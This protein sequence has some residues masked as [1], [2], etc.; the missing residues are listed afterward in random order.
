MF[1]VYI[2]DRITKQRSILETVLTEKQAIKI[3]ESWAWFYTDEDNKTY[4]LE[5]EENNM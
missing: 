2:V 5:Y 3:C 4:W 1:N